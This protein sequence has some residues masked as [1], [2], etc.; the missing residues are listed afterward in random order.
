MRT[1]IGLGFAGAAVVSLAAAGI[2]VWRPGWSAGQASEPTSFDR[3]VEGVIRQIDE[4]PRSGFQSELLRD[5]VLSEEEYDLSFSRFAD[6]IEAA[7]AVLDGNRTKNQWGLYDAGY[8]IPAI[9]YG[10]PNVKARMAAEACNSEYF[11]VVG[12]RWQASHPIPREAI[13]A[14]FARIP[15]CMR[16]KGLEPP[17]DLSPRW[18]SRWEESHS[19]EEAKLLEECIVDANRNLGM[20][21]SVGI[22]P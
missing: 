18:S 1:W 11:S 17:T 10:V 4:Q 8:S 2:W 20:P 6:C 13:D 12:Q 14:E 15:D 5:G 21:K 7:G 19:L 3:A 22:A 9:E 16:A